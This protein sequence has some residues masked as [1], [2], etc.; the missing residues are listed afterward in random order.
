VICGDKVI[1]GSEDGRLYVLA[2]DSGK[3]LWSFDIGEA[4]AGS[5]A[6]ANGLVVVGADDG[7]VYAFSDGTRPAAP[8]PAPA[9]P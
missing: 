6:V 3:S 1:V 5:P 2:L 7:V 4:I 9:K 8:A